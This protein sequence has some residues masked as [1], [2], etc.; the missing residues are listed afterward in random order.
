[1]SIEFCT[2]CGKGLVGEGTTVFKCPN[3]GEAEIGRC[4]NCRE[5]GVPYTCP[6]CGFVGP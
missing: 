1:M 5:M 2:S 6:H 4:K 3:C